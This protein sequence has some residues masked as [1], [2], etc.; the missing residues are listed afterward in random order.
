MKVLLIYKEEDKD[1]AERLKQFF[2]KMEIATETF[3]IKTPESDNTNRIS[4][5]L[6]SLSL[7]EKNREQSAN[8][9]GNPYCIYTGIN[10][11][12][13]TGDPTHGLI[14]SPVPE[15]L[16]YFLAGFACGSHVPFLVY[17]EAAIAGIPRQ[18]TFSY[19]SF[20]AEEALQK[21]FENEKAAY[22]EQDE[23]RNLIIAQ[24]TLLRMGFPLTGESLA[25]CSA[26]GGIHEVSFF[27]AAGFSSDTR[28]KAGVPILNIAA[29]KGNREVFRFL[30]LAGAQLD[31]L[32]GDRGTTALIDSVMCDNDEMVAE[33][34]KAGAELNTKSKDGQ[35]ALV[36]AVGAGNE[37]IVE[38]LLKAGADPDISDNM[39]TSARKYATLFHKS[40]ITSLFDTYAPQ[41]AV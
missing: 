34:I 6:S 35:T 32:S 26:E 31:L 10:A 25:Q 21:Y 23:E 24:E 28:N 20:T 13:P 30:I 38:A 19:T 15:P 22:K 16:C 27:L 37:K 36:V 3:D 12:G 1:A 41:K 9:K 39:G 17:G 5:L 29:R 7:G 11:G 2:K 4:K 40:S 8:S 33:L 14:I 18:V